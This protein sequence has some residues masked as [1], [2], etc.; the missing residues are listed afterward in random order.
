MMLLLTAVFGSLLTSAVVGSE[1]FDPDE[2]DP[3][4]ACYDEFESGDK[5]A[6]E[7]CCE[8][9]NNLSSSSNCEDKYYPSDVCYNEM[10]PGF[11]AVNSINRGGYPTQE[12]EECC[13]ANCNSVS[14][15]PGYCYNI[16]DDI[17]D[18]IENAVEEALP[19]WAIVL[20]SVLCGVVFL[21]ALSLIL[22]FCC[23]KPRRKEK[24][25]AKLA[26]EIQ[27]REDEDERASAGSSSTS[28]SDNKDVY[29]EQPYSV[30]HQTPNNSQAEQYVN[31]YINQYH[32]HS[33]RSSSS[34]NP[35][36]H[37]VVV[38]HQ[39]VETYD[40]P[41]VYQDGINTYMHAPAYEKYRPSGNQDGSTTFI[42]VPGGYNSNDSF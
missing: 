23:L 13:D 2:Y 27:Q 35:R 16:W 3:S 6:W 7:S 34:S 20:I 30:V 39:I 4:D 1:F 29:I 12:W 24:K 26:A 5:S 28:S 21:I 15:T 32:K 36:K 38:Q 10:I 42:H 19:E 37:H 41:P 40:R 8:K 9:D 18:D 14:C 33:S 31:Q 25:A 22:W 11:E 17:G